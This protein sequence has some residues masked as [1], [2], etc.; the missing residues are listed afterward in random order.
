[1]VR[2]LDG[3]GDLGDQLQALAQAGLPEA[4]V[5]I[6]TPPAHEFHGKVRLRARAGI[7]DAGLVVCA[8][9]GSCRRPRNSYSC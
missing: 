3:V 5:L 8:T 4:H 6:E 1:M 2:M 7:G 9:P